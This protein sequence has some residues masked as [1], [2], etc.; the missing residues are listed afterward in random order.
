MQETISR[1]T[2]Y[3]STLSCIADNL[4]NKLG[5][6]IRIRKVNGI[7]YLDYL[8]SSANTNTQV[9]NFGKNL[10]DFTKNF[11]TESLVTVLVPRGKR[12]DE[13]SNESLEAYLTVESVN[14]G[15]IYVTAEKAI[16]TYGW[17]EAVVDFSDITDANVLLTKAQDY[18]S[19]AQYEN[20]TLEVSAIDLHYLS[21]DVEAVKLLDSIRCVSP[22]HGLDRYF[23]V[24]ELSIPLDSPENTT[25]TL[26]SSEKKTLTCT[27]RTAN[28]AIIKKIES[29]PTKQNILNS[30]KENA[31]SL[32]N[33]ATN[34][35]VSIAQG[36]NGSESL[37]ISDTSD[38]TVA[39]RLW[40][41]SV[42]GLGY[43][44]DG[45]ATYGLA[46]TMDG[47]IVADYIT[48]G[49][50][51]ADIIRAGT[52]KDLN[53]KTTLDLTTG[54]LTVN[55]GEIGGYTIDA[56]S[57]YNDVVELNSSGLYFK[58][59]SIDV[60]GFGTGYWVKDATKKGLVMNLDYTGTYTGWL[61]SDNAENTLYSLKM[62][63]TKDDLLQDDGST[64]P[65]GKISF[66]CDLYG[67]GYKLCN[68]WIDPDTGGVNGGLTLDNGNIVNI[69][70][71]GSR[72]FSARIQNGILLPA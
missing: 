70:L 68:F 34:G 25:Y 43:S 55:Y 71:S 46:M 20:M 48:T 14:G 54:Y 72:Y 52:L 12:L 22:P 6:H 66:G 16:E 59:S 53:G 7:R 28:E 23:L 37:I 1:V 33:M 61:V 17:I 39:T 44:K 45:G 60:G 29:M 69:M 4:V 24:T 9:I 65:G 51:T 8:G 18:L 32:I 67:N 21:K 38:Y 15:S 36:E 3:E 50:L 41:W 63:Y 27:N 62:A 30:A 49:V 64:L 40:K 19:N 2:N 58:N 11:D 47:A 5:G 26:G 31:T 57:I 35:F 13:S 10:L 42:N 56:V